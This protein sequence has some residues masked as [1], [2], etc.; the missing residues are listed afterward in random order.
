MIKVLNYTIDIFLIGYTLYFFLFVLLGLKTKKNDK[1][2]KPKNKFAVVIPA[3]NEEKVIEKLIKNIKKLKYPKELY[4][5]YV[6]ADNCSDNTAQKARN[7]GVN[8]FIRYN[9]K[10]KG[11]GYALKYAFNK[12]GFISGE[13][14]YDAAVVFDADNLVKDNF[15]L[16]M[17]TRLLDGEKIIQSY[18]DS[19]NPSDNWV[20][21]TFSMMFWINDRF[22][23]LSRYNVGL[24]SVL[25]GTGMCISKESL[26]KTGWNTVTL[27]EDLEYSVQALLKDTKT[28]FARETKIYDE[29]PLSF[30]ASCRQRLRWGR[31]QLSVLFKY[32]P[33][34]LKQG[35]L[36]RK[37]IKIDSALRLIQQ[38]FLMTYFV[39]T[40]FRLLFPETFHSPIFN[41]AI[42]NIKTLGFVLP[43]M[44]FIIPSSVYFLDDLSFKSFKYV[45]LFPVFMYSWVLIL[46]YALFTI[47]D[48]SWLPTKH[49]RNL[50]RKELQENLK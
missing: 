35:I 28:T 13:T 42:E 37:V 4:D 48:K 7:L 33:K 47:N 44:P 6:V 25:M 41:F 22:N 19:K 1:F 50:S 2:K 32:I 12:L 14:N 36:E 20:T 10:N 18:I 39:V 29:K 26:K 9:N 3:H 45:L 46:Y 43:V 40:I 11:K 16:A 30:Y 21:A 27:T 5:I 23:L 31:G 17:N 24:S 34:M 49:F 15:L 8:V 38:P